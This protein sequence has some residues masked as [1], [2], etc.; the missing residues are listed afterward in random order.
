MRVDLSAASLPCGPRTS[1]LAASARRRQLSGFPGCVCLCVVCV[2]RTPWCWR[3]QSTMGGS[4][5]R[6]AFWKLFL[7]S[8]SS[9]L[10]GWS[11]ES[12]HQAG[13]SP[14]HPTPDLSNRL[15]S[16]PSCTQRGARALLPRERMGGGLERERSG[17]GGQRVEAGQAGRASSASS[18]P[19]CFVTS[20]KLPPLSGQQPLLP[21]LGRHRAHKVLLE[22]EVR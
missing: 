16:R 10:V 8:L 15:C 3:D 19:C 13:S 6:L 12:T 1:S 18:C 11:P 17:R 22:D 9:G 2:V 7:P 5:R 4:L 20:G 14:P 21:G